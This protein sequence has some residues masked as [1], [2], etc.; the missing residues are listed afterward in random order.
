MRK[1]IS[2]MLGASIVFGGLLT[3]TDQASA[4]KSSGW[5]PPGLQKKFGMKADFMPGR[6]LTRAHLAQFIAIQDEDFREFDDEEEILAKVTDYKAIPASFRRAVA[7][8]ISEELMSYKSLPNGKILFQ[9]N[10][11]VPWEE[12]LKIFK[13]IE[14]VPNAERTT[15][16]YKGTLR[17]IDEIGDKT[18]VVLQTSQGLRTAYYTAANVPGG[19]V[20]GVSLEVKVRDYRI[21]ESSLKPTQLLLDYLVFS[22]K[23]DPVNPRVGEE[24]TLKPQLANTSQ[25][26]I[27]LEN[28][29]Y[30]FSIKRVNGGGEWEFTARSSQ[31]LNIPASSTSDPVS[32]V[33]PSSTWIP[34]Q[35][36]EYIITGVKL[37]I[38]NGDWQSIK[39]KQESWTVNLLTANQSSVETGTA[40]FTAYANDSEVVLSRSTSEQWQGESSLKVRTSG[41][42]PWQGVNVYHNGSS[43]SGSL[44]YSFYIK[45]PQDTPIRVR[46]YDH[47]NDSYPAG[48]S[49]EFTASGAWQRKSVTFTPQSNTGRLSLQTTLNNYSQITTFYL[50]GLQL[51]RGSEA[52]AWTLGGTNGSEGIIILP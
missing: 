48:G 19:L 26:A 25:R 10:N 49:L 27:A 6:Y 45:A 34:G 21:I 37:R 40:G 31:D 29:I 52:T 35:S 44:T 2:I 50:D 28:V 51:Q 36:G 46:I 12:L 11:Q 42:N 8:V 7:F 20:V 5:I 33:R 43:L 22:V 1:I 47:T 4:A 24:V 41:A 38:N 9:P 13:S 32:L 30:R 15:Q 39:V 17:M 3:F 16:T 23:T 18:W 14:L